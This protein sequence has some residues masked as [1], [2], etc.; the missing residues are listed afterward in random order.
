MDAR[1]IINRI[2]NTVAMDGTYNFKGELVSYEN[3]YQVSFEVVGIHTMGHINYMADKAYSKLIE[4][5]ENELNS[6]PNLGV[7]EGVAEVSFHVNE[8]DK[9]MAIAKRYNQ[10][11]IWSW[12]EMDIILNKDW[13][14]KENN[15]R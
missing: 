14:Q 10:H 12:S 11:S 6:K 7:F 13:K 3:G 9:A 5:L 8:L 15:I 1:K 2:R 4:A